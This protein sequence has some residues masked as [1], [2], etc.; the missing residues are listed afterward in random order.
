MLVDGIH[1]VLAA[2]AG[3]IALLGTKASRKDSQD[4]LFP[5]LALSTCTMPYV[6]YQQVGGSP[7]QESFEG[8]GRL[9]SARFR[10]TCYGTT[11]KQALRLAN[12]LKRA[13]LSLGGVLRP[14][15]ADKTEVHGSWLRLEADD[16]ESIPHGTIYA[17]HRDFEV[18]YLDGDDE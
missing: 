13:M 16:S 11:Y 14:S 17:S 7:L 9:Q 12:A 1:A 2:D 18:I 10:F 5:T 3:M 8:T 4:G 15:S 6:V